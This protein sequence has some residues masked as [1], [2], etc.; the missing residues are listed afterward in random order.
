MLK[1]KIPQIV[2]LTPTDSKPKVNRPIRRIKKGAT[3]YRNSLTLI[4]RGSGIRTHD[5]LLPKQV[6]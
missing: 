2:T 4:R 5:P 3:F 6:R 1:Y